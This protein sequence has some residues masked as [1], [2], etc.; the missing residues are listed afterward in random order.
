MRIPSSACVRRMWL[1]L[2]QPE[3]RRCGLHG[4]H[5]QIGLVACRYSARQSSE[6]IMSTATRTVL[7]P[8][9]VGGLPVAAKWNS[10]SI[11][12][13]GEAAA[14]QLRMISPVRWHYHPAAAAAPRSA[15]SRQRRVAR[16][17][18]GWRADQP[19]LLA[20]PPDSLVPW[21]RVRS[22]G[23]E[24]GL[25]LHLRPGSCLYVPPC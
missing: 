10:G 13:G 17:G 22:A 20:R 9:N 15:S 12:S 1:P 21:L 23:W 16:G 7:H 5:A 25:Y 4:S 19:A 24:R 3:W 18:A 8:S 2:I 6:A 11:Q 14:F